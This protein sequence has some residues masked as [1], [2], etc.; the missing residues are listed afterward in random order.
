MSV[1]LV[2]DVTVKDRGAL[3][4]Y[5]KLSEH[6]LAPYSGKFHVQAGDLTVIEG[7]WNPTVIIIAEF[8]SVDM[9]NAWYSSDE[10]AAALKVKS[11]AMDRNMILVKGIK[12]PGEKQ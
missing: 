9:A 6:T 2:C 12:H 7:D 1:F 11:R 3:R 4:E 10:Y 5:L 8:P